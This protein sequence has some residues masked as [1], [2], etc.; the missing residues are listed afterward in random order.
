M[1]IIMTNHKEPLLEFTT[2]TPRVLMAI[3]NILQLNFKTA[4]LNICDSGLFIQEYKDNNGQITFDVLLR[5]E[6]FLKFRVP[7]IESEGEGVKFISLGFQTEDFKASLST[8]SKTDTLTISLHPSDTDVLRIL[9]VKKSNSASINQHFTLCASSSQA[10]LTPR[11]VNHL[12]TVTV[13]IE[14][15]QS[16]LKGMKKGVHSYCLV[17]AQE[18]G[19]RFSEGNKSKIQGGGGVL[20]IYNDSLPP[21]CSYYVSQSR[22]LSFVQLYK[23]SNNDT[24]KIYTSP[25]LPLRLSSNAGALGPMNMYLTTA[26]DAIA[27]PTTTTQTTAIDN[28][29]T[30]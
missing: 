22:L 21:T 29:P 1:S 17:E 7:K 4:T 2:G 13:A 26:T 25:D 28:Q 12:P 6:N 5:A 30:W 9:I 16:I 24:I 14:S 10:V 19:V 15:Y 20:G 27:P 11:Y 3:A 18:K 23:I 8:I